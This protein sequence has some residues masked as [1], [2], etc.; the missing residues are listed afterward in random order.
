MNSLFQKF[1]GFLEAEVR[2]GVAVYFRFYSEERLHETLGYR[3][4]HEINLGTPAR[5]M[6]AAEAVVKDGPARDRR[7]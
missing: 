2:A 7:S 6:P 1:P 3:P 4:P 5:R